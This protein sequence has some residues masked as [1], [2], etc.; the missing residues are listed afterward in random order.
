M[1]R[2]SSDVG[3]GMI[4]PIAT[5]WKGERVRSDP[6]RSAGPP[7]TAPDT[8]LHEQFAR[9]ARTHPDAIALIEDGT[10]TSYW[11][12]DATADAW[13]AEL[14]AAGVRPGALVLAP[15]PRSVALVTALLAVLKSGAA[16]SLPA[17]DWPE[18][19]IRDVL[20]D[21]N[22]PLL[23]APAGTAAPAGSEVPIWSPPVGKVAAPSGFQPASVSADDPCCVFF[24]SGTTGRPKGVLSPHRATARLFQPK[25]FARFAAD[26]TMPLAAATPWDAFSLE[27]WSVLLNGGT[28]VIVTEP[29]LSAA[30]RSEAVARH[31]TDTVWLTSSLFN[32]IVDE[33]PEA[34]RGLHQV[35]VGGERLSTPHVQTNQ[36]GHPGSVLLNGYGPVEST[37]FATTHRVAE[38]DCDRPRGVPLGRPVPGPQ[39]YVL[40]GTRAC[41]VAEVGE[42]CLAGDGLALGYLNDPTLTEEKFQRRLVEG[43]RVRVY[44]TGD[45]GCRDR[46]GLLHYRG[47]AARQVKL[48]GHRVDPAEVE[49]QVERR[50]P[51]VR[52]CRVVVWDCV[53]GDGRE[54]A[55]FCVPTR[56]GAPL[57]GALPV[58]RGALVAYPRPAAVVSVDAFAV[59]A[60]G[61]RG[62][63]A[64]LTM[65]PQLFAPPDVMPKTT[66]TNNTPTT[67]PQDPLAQ[68][69]ADAFAAVTGHD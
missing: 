43:R 1:A 6:T 44:R 48:R 7:N 64:L 3:Y 55:A 2:L 46:D 67:E 56:T 39:V 12:L 31:G 63:R 33:A 18:Q 34:F 59:T 40:D 58:L 11:E 41:A 49:R 14:V 4:S 42:I 22:S 15:F 5:T 69:V 61:E 26:T 36:R 21:L 51:D 60:Q 13:A 53:A 66:K 37:V 38:A 52:H 35:M 45:L 23:V 57:D 54:L 28:S 10:A 20:G 24:T 30:A 32:M 50:L 16:Y 27:L 8:G 62:G 25:G 65:A 9:T 17:P 19:R 68:T 47:R 29:Y